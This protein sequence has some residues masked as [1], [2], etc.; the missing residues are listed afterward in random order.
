MLLVPN[1]G[2]INPAKVDAVLQSKEGVLI[3]IDGQAHLAASF[4]VPEA[5]HVK[6][7]WE[8]WIGQVVEGL[9]EWAFKKKLRK[10]EKDVLDLR[11]KSYEA[12]SKIKALEKE[13]GELKKLAEGVA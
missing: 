1:V 13:L 5:T 7:T 8:N 11:Y 10:A 3:I 6:T 4:Y 9:S 12:A 2:L